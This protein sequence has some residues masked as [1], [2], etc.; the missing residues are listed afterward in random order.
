MSKSRRHIYHYILNNRDE[1]Y[2]IDGI[3]HLENTIEN[4][5]SYRR[6]KRLITQSD[7]IDGCVITSLSYL[8]QETL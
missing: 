4:Q 6:L 8:G 1:G 2:T 3:A 7:D 5:E